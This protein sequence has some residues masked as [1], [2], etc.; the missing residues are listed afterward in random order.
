VQVSLS[1]FL[2]LFSA[3]TQGPFYSQRPGVLLFCGACFALTISTILA[4][5]WPTTTLDDLPVKGLARGDYGL[6]AIWVWI[7]CIVWWLIQDAA[8]V[9]KLFGSGVR[10]MSGW[11]R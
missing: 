3:R 8:K 10:M 4:C 2:T 6:W 9:R 11:F 1:D 7:Y 5:V